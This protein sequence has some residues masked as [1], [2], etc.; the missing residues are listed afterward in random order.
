MYIYSKHEWRRSSE[1]RPPSGLWTI[2][3]QSRAAIVRVPHVAGALHISPNCIRKSCE[4]QEQS[5]GNSGKRL[6][7]PLPLT[8]SIFDANAV[9]VAVAAAIAVNAAGAWVISS[10]RQCP[11]KPAHPSS[12]IQRESLIIMLDPLLTSY[13]FIQQINPSKVIVV[14][15]LQ[16]Q[17]KL[18]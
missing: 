5:F 13:E 7:S 8:D 14:G 3:S 4:M 18:I 1:N 2:C 15:V 17:F 6:S 10:C 11:R 16:R 9:A 12:T